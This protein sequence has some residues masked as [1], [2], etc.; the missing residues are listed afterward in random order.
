MSV[1]LCLLSYK[2]CVR[3][4][5][6]RCVC[7]WLLPRRLTV[8][9]GTD[10]WLTGFP[11][12]AGDC[13]CVRCCEALLLSSLSVCMAA[14]PCTDILSGSGIPVEGWSVSFIDGSTP[15]T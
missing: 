6:T 9:W 4:V 2:L 1:W 12:Y 15:Y 14:Y 8:D 3:C 13:K 7:V 10:G 5:C 11:I